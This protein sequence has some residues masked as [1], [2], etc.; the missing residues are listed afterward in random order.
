MEAETTEKCC[1]PWPVF[2]FK[3]GS[4]VQGFHSSSGLGHS[5]KSLVKK[6]SQRLAYRSVL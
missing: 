6:M 5:Y 3:L 4:Y 1:S 2:F